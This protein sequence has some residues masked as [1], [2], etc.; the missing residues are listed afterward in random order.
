MRIDDHPPAPSAARSAL[1]SAGSTC[2]ARAVASVA[3]RGG[4]RLGARSAWQRPTIPAAGAGPRAAL[5]T[6]S[7]L[8]RTTLALAAGAWA[9][10]A[11]GTA[12]AAPART[13][14]LSLAA[15]RP[16][17]L[18]AF[19]WWWGVLKNPRAAPG[20]TGPPNRLTRGWLGRPRDLP[21]RPVARGRRAAVGR[22]LRSSPRCPLS[23]RAAPARLAAGGPL[24]SGAGG[25]LFAGV[26]GLLRPAACGLLPSRAPGLRLGT[27]AGSGRRGRLAVS[28]RCGRRAVA[29][30]LR[31]RRLCARA[32][33]EGACGLGLLDA[34]GRG[35]HP[36]PG[37]LEDG[38][39][40]LRG[41]SSLL[42][43]LVDALLCH[44]RTKS[45]VSSW[46]VTGARNDRVS[47]RPGPSVS[48]H[49]GRRHT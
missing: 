34:R 44:S 30:G 1:A 10:V 29:A 6:G 39:G 21:R 12:G 48:A 23:S 28:L 31:L 14:A 37:L 38:Q 5:A 9:A 2:G 49:S 45:M 42:R 35:G 16:A 8:T 33:A 22:L 41:D 46:T 32:V 26:R 17:L 4:T 19:L 27:R 47:G 40:F 20:G 13:I 36:E 3:S 18:A 7:A 25:L 11:A 15:A 43:Y 24:P